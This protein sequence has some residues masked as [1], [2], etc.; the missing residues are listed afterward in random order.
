[1]DQRTGRLYP[2]APLEKIDLVQRLEEKLNDVKS[3]D[4]HI[5]NIK[6][7]YILQKQNQQ[8]IKKIIKV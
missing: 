8:I 6:N 3:F 4:N 7:D 1:M 2:T 5:N